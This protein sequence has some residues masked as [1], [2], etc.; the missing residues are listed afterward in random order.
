MSQTNIDIRQAETR[1]LQDQLNSA[2]VTQ[3][4]S[5]L[6]SINSEVTVPGRL[7]AQTTPSLVV[8]VGTGDMSNPN[9]SKH[10]ILAPITGTVVSFAGGTITFPSAPTGGTITVSPGVNNTI[11]IGA[12]QFIAVLVQLSNTG[13]LTVS[14]GAAAGSIGAV[15][16]PTGSMSPTVISLGYII[17]E[18]NGSSVIQN[19]VNGRLYQFVAAAAGSG[20]LVRA[21]PT[22]FLSPAGN[23]DGLTFAAALAAIPASGG[24]ILLLDDI[25]VTSV[26]TIPKNVKLLAR[27]RNASVIFGVGGS[28]S[29]TGNDVVFEEV[30]FTSTTSPITYIAITGNNFQCKSCDFDS[31]SATDTNTFLSIT[32]NYSDIANCLFRKTLYPST[33]NAIQYNSG[34]AGNTYRAL[35]YT[36]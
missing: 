5:T 22:F 17:V 32:G 4:D 11:V 25:T 20:T 30:G 8:N 23:G 7:I 9:T 27:D 1:V 21:Y 19:I 31:A 10:R 3:M 12:N 2:V 6:A 36:T 13:Q 34:S 29:V 18:S 28:I 35:E 26:I 16:V 24:V 15:I 33:C 14:V